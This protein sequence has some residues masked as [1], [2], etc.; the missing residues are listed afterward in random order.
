MINWAANPG[1]NANGA[2]LRPLA[3]RSW[4]RPDRNFLTRPLLLA[5][6]RDRVPGLRHTGS[7][8]RLP[9]DETTFLSFH[10]SE[11]R[12]EWL[13]PPP[14][15]RHRWPRAVATSGVTSTLWS[16]TRYS[17]P[18][19]R[20][21]SELSVPPARSESPRLAD[22]ERLQHSSP[23]SRPPT[24]SLILAG[25]AIPGLVVL[26]PHIVAM[27]R[28]HLTNSLIRPRHCLLAA[29][30]ARFRLHAA[31]SNARP[32]CRD[33]GVGHGRRLFPGGRRAQD[34]CAPSSPEHHRSRRFQIHSRLGRVPLALSL[35]TSSS[36]R[37]VPA[38]RAGSV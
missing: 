3:A 19:A 36:V 24:M 32:P 5:L 13:L 31:L 26:V 16:L 28:L 14:R 23:R 22:T 17:R 10:V 38:R 8:N 35:L 15:R 34:N 30:V 2:L 7:P 25:Q 11:G 12:L 9:L 6:G 33:R 18:R 27:Q 21:I 37:T 1:L 29:R 20:S 4:P